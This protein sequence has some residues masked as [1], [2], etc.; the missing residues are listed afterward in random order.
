MVKLNKTLSQERATLL[1]KCKASVRD[2]WIMVIRWWW[3]QDNGLRKDATTSDWDLSPPYRR[4]RGT[5]GA[6]ATSSLYFQ[7]SFVRYL[8]FVKYTKYINIEISDQRPHGSIL[9]SFVT[10]FTEHLQHFQPTKWKSTQNIYWISNLDKH[11][12][13]IGFFFGKKV[14]NV[15]GW[16]GP[17]LL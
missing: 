3:W 6:I 2:R 17:K 15:G 9:P 5:W 8:V 13:I 10:L 16:V 4:L 1:E 14:P 11:T 7:L 12:S